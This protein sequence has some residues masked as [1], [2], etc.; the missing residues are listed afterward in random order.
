MHIVAE[1]CDTIAS[2][3]KAKAKTKVACSETWQKPV[4]LGSSSSLPKQDG[5]KASY[6][7]ESNH[8]ALEIFVTHYNK[9]QYEGVN[10]AH[11][12]NT[13][14]IKLGLTALTCPGN[15]KDFT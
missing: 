6:Y 13:S 3:Q 8:F 5:K 15:L 7:S 14:S 2:A 10:Y 9:K 11:L 1:G 4:S 12:E